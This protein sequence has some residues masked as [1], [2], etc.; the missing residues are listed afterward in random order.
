MR[1]HH[2]QPW[3]R[4]RRILALALAVLALPLALAEPAAAQNREFSGKIAKVG[5][6][7]V[8][9]DNG[10]GERVKFRKTNATVVLDERPARLRHSPREKWADL[11]VGDWVAVEWRL[12]DKPRRVYR[13]I[14]L[15]PRREER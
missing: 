14:V 11:R 4:H 6:K 9:V 13:V 1:A 15:P 10:M 12:S 3:R 8:W 2:P 5:K 7:R